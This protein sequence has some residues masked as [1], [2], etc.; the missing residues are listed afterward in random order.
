MAGYCST[1]QSPQ[2]AVVLMEEEYARTH[3]RTHAAPHPKI[4]TVFIL[5]KIHENNFSR[6]VTHLK[7][8]LI[9]DIQVLS[10]YVVR[11]TDKSF[12]LNDAAFVHRSLNNFTTRHA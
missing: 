11:E 2:R 6:E 5:N 10:V 1:G 3:A 7:C 9:T 12:L 4:L 8:T